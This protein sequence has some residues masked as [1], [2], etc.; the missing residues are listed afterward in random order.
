VTKRDVQSAVHVEH[1]HPHFE[2]RLELASEPE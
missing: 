2:P 1:P